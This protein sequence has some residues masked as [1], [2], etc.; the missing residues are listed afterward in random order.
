MR[1]FPV[2]MDLDNQMVV[3]V[4]GSEQ[5][6]QKL[7]LL[8]RTGAR[9]RVLAFEVCDEVASL[10]AQRRIA[11]ERRSLQAR[12]LADAR[13][14]YVALDNDREAAMAVAM[15]RAAGVPVN[16]VDRQELCDFITPA[17]VDR[18]PVVVAIGTE[19]TAPVLARQIKSRLE[20]MLPASLGEF[21]RWAAGLRQR[22]AD[23]IADGRIRRRFWD[24]LFDGPIARAYLAGNFAMANDLADRELAGAVPVRGRVSLVGAGPGDPDLLTVKAVRALQEADVIVADR[25][26]GPK[27]LDRARRD[28]RRI[29]V[30]KTPGRPSPTQ[31]EINA[32][33]VREAS[34]GQYV[35]RLKGGDPM[36][37]GRGGEELTAL[38]TAG[39]TVDVVPGI[40]AAL[41]CAA[42]A[43]RQSPSGNSAAA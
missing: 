41:G 19:G 12:D 33:L 38:R 8:M 10:A 1:F 4:G 15:A 31:A 32:I 25:L 11:L 28:A 20:A 29:L 3:V 37:F 14:V 7:R 36:V 2:F 27:I 34:A 21:A 43:G 24:G 13:L 18:D 17:I 23:V 26:V 35:V 16:A 39:I 40:T 30:G 22:A 5:A 42:V 6:A 9:L